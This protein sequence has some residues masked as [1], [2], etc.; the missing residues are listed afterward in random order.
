MKEI[1][2][3]PD[4]DILVDFF[5][6][7]EE[8]VKFVEDNSKKFILSAIVVAELYAGIRDDNERDILEDFTSLFKIIPVT[9]EI[10]K[11][12]GFLR[13]R[14]GKSHGI[15]IADA[16]VA[17]TAMVEGAELKTLNIKHYPM[18]QGIKPPYRKG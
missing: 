17:A 2:I 16:L 5:R 7:V 14:F 13:N 3:L 15:G 18:F 9:L 6:G 1:P 4:T 11:L 12:A 8:A 10:A